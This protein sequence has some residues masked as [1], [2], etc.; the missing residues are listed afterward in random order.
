MN[1][2]RKRDLTI[3]AIVAAIVIGGGAMFLSG[4]E[5]SP[6]AVNPTPSP[7]ADLYRLPVRSPLPMRR[8]H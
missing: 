7:I 5:P 8:R 4:G 2:N 3:A 6:D 1:P